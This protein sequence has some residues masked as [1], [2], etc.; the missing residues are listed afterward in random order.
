MK[1]NR[2]MKTLI[3]LLTLLSTLFLAFQAVAV[4]DAIKQ[5]IQNATKI[6][7]D[8][9]LRNAEA[10]PGNWLSHGRTY[11]EQRYS[12]LKQINQDNLDKL[13]LAWTLDLGTKRGIQATPLVVDGIMFFTGPWSVVHAVDSRTGKML[14]TYDPQVPRDVAL[15]LCCGVVN[16]G[17]ALYEGDLFVGTLDGRLVSVDAASGTKNWEVMTVPEDTFYTI[18]GAPRVVNGKVLIGN[19]G[20][21]YFARGYVTAYDAKSGKQVWRFY[22][23]PGD[24]S[25]PFEHPDLKEAAKTWSGEWWKNGGGGGTAWDA[26]VF[27]PELNTVYIGVGNGTHWNR[28]IR[29]PGGGDN[30]YLSSIVAVDADTGSYKWHYQTTPGDTWDYTATQHIILADLTIDGKPR[31]VLMQAP[32]N[33]FFYVIDRTNGEFISGDAYTYVSW[34]KGIDDNGRPIETKN[35]RYLDGKTHWITPSSHGGHNWHPMSFNPNTG[36]VYVPAVRQAGPY[37]NTTDKTKMAGGTSITNVSIASYTANETVFDPNPEA[38]EPGTHTGR[39]I[40]YDPLAHEVKW[41]VPQPYHYNGGLLST[42][43]DLLLQGDAEGMFSVRDPLTGEVLWQ[44]DVRTGA[45]SPPVTYLVDGEQYISLLV[46]WGSGQGLKVKGVEQLHPG[47]LYTF[48]LGGNATPPAKMEPVEKPFTTLAS[49]GTPQQIG[50]GYDLFVNNCASCHE[51]GK[52]GGAAPDL[53]RSYA[54]ILNILEDILLRGAFAS[55]GMP[56]FAKYL[57]EED[58]EN[59]RH[60]ISYSAQE[61]SRGTPRAEYMKRMAQLQQQVHE[62]A[63]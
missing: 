47:T 53:T 45:I 26:I 38:P 11:Q 48:K 56:S 42:A 15:K 2:N 24:P 25:K 32:K 4:E 50:K 28:E 51:L 36:W 21:E 62:Q 22:T 63:N 6:I 7:D 27:D 20:A 60:Y 13:G 39:L 55:Q 43:G 18:T 34:A 40:A 8:D 33:G 52:G 58:V 54:P 3:S 19:G 9:A 29:S 10:T 14:W 35:A 31:K 37:I 30:L 49:T 57:N 23:V 46:G 5:K 59:L 12:P 16:R 17:L 61:F 44:F 1:R 41:E